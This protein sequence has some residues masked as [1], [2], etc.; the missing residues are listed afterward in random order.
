MTRLILLLLVALVGGSVAAAS[1]Q[2]ATPVASPPTGSQKYLVITESSNHIFEMVEEEP[3]S[4]MEGLEIRNATSYKL[5]IELYLDGGL[6]TRVSV[7][8]DDDFFYAVQTS[9]LYRIVILLNDEEVHETEIKL[10]S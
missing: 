10:D 9:G 1:A 7:P 8:G 3:T 4:D 5:R 2:Q 6:M